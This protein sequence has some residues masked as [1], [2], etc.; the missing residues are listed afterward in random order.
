M[1]RYCVKLQAQSHHLALDSAEKS[2]YRSDFPPF[3]ASRPEN[4]TQTESSDVYRNQQSSL[5]D[6]FKWDRG[7]NLPAQEI[8]WG[9]RLPFAT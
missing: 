2:W 5:P 8:I 1:L 4:K 6:G 3:G 9:I 7:M